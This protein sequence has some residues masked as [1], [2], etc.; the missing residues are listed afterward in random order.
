MSFNY[1]SPVPEIEAEHKILCNIFMEMEYNLK[2]DLTSLLNKMRDNSTIHFRN[3]EA[4]MLHYNYPGY[5]EHVA[6]H[7]KLLHI[8][9]K[10]IEHYSYSHLRNYIYLRFVEIWLNNHFNGL[11]KKLSTYLIPLV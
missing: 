3:E 9:S 4:I 8:L 1:Y 5:E 10:L 11:D 2:H 7:N 6:A